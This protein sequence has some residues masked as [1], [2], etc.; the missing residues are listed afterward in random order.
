MQQ[1]TS[2]DSSLLSFSREALSA[3]EEKGMKVS[4]SSSIP[5]HSC[6]AADFSPF[7]AVKFKKELNYNRRMHKNSRRKAIRTPAIS[8]PDTKHWH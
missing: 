7:T 1:V 8:P 3:L 4:A 6:R 2:Q 5:S